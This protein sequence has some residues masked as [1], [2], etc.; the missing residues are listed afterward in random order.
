MIN[1]AAKGDMNADGYVDGADTD[2][3]RAGFGS[4]FSLSDLLRYVMRV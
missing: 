3:V 2:L 1:I 4:G